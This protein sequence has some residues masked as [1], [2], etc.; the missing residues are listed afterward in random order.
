MWLILVSIDFCYYDSMWIPTGYPP[1]PHMAY[2]GPYGYH[3]VYYGYPPYPPYAVSFVHCVYRKDNLIA[4][5]ECSFISKYCSL[6]KERP[7]SKERPPPTFGPISCI[8]SKFAQISA[9]PGVSFAWL[10][11][12]T[13]GVT[14]RQLCVDER[15]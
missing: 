14:T 1:P 12:C 6:A 10:M 3:P 8:G 13:H 5:T 7:P 4:S 15:S 11:E 9:H 2:P